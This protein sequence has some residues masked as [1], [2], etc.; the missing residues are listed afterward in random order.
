MKERT[1]TALLYKHTRTQTHLSDATNLPLVSASERASERR[2][3]VSL[4]LLARD[5]RTHTH[6]HIAGGVDA[7][8]RPTCTHAHTTEGAPAH[9]RTRAAATH[10]HTRTSLVRNLILILIAVQPM[11]FG[12]LSFTRCSLLRDALRARLR[13]T[14]YSSCR[15]SYTAFVSRGAAA[16]GLIVQCIAL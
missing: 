1:I 14:S 2:I 5:A 12:R 9:E 10:A 4:P 11:P 8:A 7:H 15:A 13:A 16:S 3:C 6:A